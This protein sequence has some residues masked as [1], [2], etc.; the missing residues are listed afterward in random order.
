MME[1]PF[2]VDVSPQRRANLHR[3]MNK[4]M[5]GDIVEK[6]SLKETIKVDKTSAWK[7]PAKFRHYDITISL[8]DPS[9]YADKSNVTVS[10][11]GEMT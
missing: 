9:Q 7:N 5:L 2:K 6:V 4:L 11:V 8:L 10:Q 1:A 3:R